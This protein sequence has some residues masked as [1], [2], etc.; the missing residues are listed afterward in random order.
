MKGQILIVSGPS[1]SGKSTLLNRL[2]KEEDNLYFSISSTTRP[3][4]NGE[5]EG[6]DYYFIDEDEFKY[7]IDND[8]FLEWAC[9]H[10]NYYGTSLKPVLKALNDG[11]IVVFDIDVQGFCIAREKLKNYIT[12]VFVT[13][14]NKDELEKR[15][16]K[17]NTDSNETIKNRLT[18]AAV[19]MEH[20]S[21]YD[22]FLINDDIEKSYMDLLSIVRSMRVK[23]SIVNI[24]EV[25]D[26]WKNC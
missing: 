16:Q 13:T 8:E 10:K 7:G 19:E 9:V 12:S 26:N 20:I 21:E 3:R 22:Y 5:R 6:V 11:K 14:K 23:S 25:I 15:L 24:T 17:R 2:F 18:N 4:R 1:G